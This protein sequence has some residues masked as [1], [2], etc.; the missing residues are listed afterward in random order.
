MKKSSSKSARTAGSNPIATQG[1]EIM[2]TTIPEQP[3]QAG[4][5]VGQ[6]KPHSPKVRLLPVDGS[7]QPILSNFSKLEVT[8]GI[9]YIDFGFVEPGIV[10]ALQRAV[11]S[12]AALPEQINGRMATRVALSVDTLQALHQQIGQALE[13]LM[14]T[15]QQQITTLAEIMQKGQSQAMQTEASRS[16]NQQAATDDV[17]A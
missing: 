12:G 7:D 9:V 6:Q 4:A 16:A 1:E 15:A 2:Q 11:A 13:K 8:P 17:T 5:N 10:A 14:E 3:S